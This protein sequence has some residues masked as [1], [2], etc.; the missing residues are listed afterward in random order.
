MK[1]PK[2]EKS[3]L[4]T[5]NAG[6]VAGTLI[7]DTTYKP[8]K[9]YKRIT[10][11]AV[12]IL[13]PNNDATANFISCGIN[14]GNRGVLHDDVP[15]ENFAAS[16]NV[17]PDDKFKTLNQPIKGQTVKSRVTTNLLSVSTFYVYFVYRIEDSEEEIS[18][19]P[20]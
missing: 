2:Y 9:D 11:V 20:A 13:N 8:D 6:T 12:H 16:S 5:V 1:I 19:S 18:Q 4:I 3:G 17:K 7:E 10:G 14:D 15:F